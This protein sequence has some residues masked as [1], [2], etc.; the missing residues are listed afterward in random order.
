MLKASELEIITLSENTSTGRGLIAEWGISVLI[1]AGGRSF[2]LDGGAG[3]SVAYNVD[4]LGLDL[5]PVEAVVLS[6]GHSDHTGGLP[7]LLRRI[8]RGEVEIVAHPAVWEEKCSRNRTTGA[9]RYAGIPYRREELERIGARFTL[10][11][12]PHWLTDDIVASG[13][14]PMTTEFEAVADNLLVRRNGEYVPDDMADDQSVFIK[15]DAGLVVVLGCAHRGIVNI[16]R[17]AQE[18]TGV[19]PVHAVIEGT[20][21]APASED[22]VKRT[23]DALEEIGVRHLGVS[24]CTGLPVAA[25]LSREFGD[26]FFFN[27]A[28]TRLRFPL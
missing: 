21:L 26:R 2:I 19:Q 4:T 20:H 8:P 27:N 23:V 12:G 17:Y 7:A 18:L 16:L 25:R 22:Q 9:V 6:H 13:E 11:A 1:S 14:E 5:A 10:T 15:T 28:G 3:D 24:H